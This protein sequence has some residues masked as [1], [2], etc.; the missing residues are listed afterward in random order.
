MTETKT[1]T[2]CK[3]TKT[4]NLF[5]MRNGVATS[6]CKQCS[7]EKAKA[8]YR[9]K[10]PNARDMNNY[11]LKYGKRDDPDYMIKYKWYKKYNLTEEKIQLILDK[12]DNACAICKTE[13]QDQSFYVDH[14]HRCCSGTESCGVCV[15]GF[16][17]NNCNNGLGKL[18]DS[19]AILRSAIEYLEV[20]P[21]YDRRRS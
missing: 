1:C 16:L 14:D 20:N 12:Q 8:Y 18:Q 10:N 13:F 11:D 7:S 3:E 15:R 9:K 5:T 2:Q 6:W 4:I 21:F 19:P 17:C